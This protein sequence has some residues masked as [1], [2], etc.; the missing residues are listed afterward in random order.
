MREIGR[1]HE[2]HRVA[3]GFHVK[4]YRMDEVR[5]AQFAAYPAIPTRE[6]ESDDSAGRGIVYHHPTPNVIPVTASGSH[7]HACQMVATLD[8]GRVGWY[9]DLDIRRMEGLVHQLLAAHI[10]KGDRDDDQ[11]DHRPYEPAKPF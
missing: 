9:R 2:Q 6:V 8:G 3:V 11:H 1:R 5:V 10:N 4:P 7:D